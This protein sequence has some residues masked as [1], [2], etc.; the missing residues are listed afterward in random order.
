MTAILANPVKRVTIDTVEEL[1]KSDLDCGAWGEENRNL[2]T[3]STDEATQ[4]IGAKLEHIDDAEAAV[5]YLCDPSNSAQ[6][7][8]SSPSSK[9]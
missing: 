5:S 1:S 4:A 3:S 6:T 2:F 7:F 9:G 8:I